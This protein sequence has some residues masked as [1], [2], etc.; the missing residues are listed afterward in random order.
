MKVGEEA[1]QEGAT[2]VLEELGIF[3][4]SVI[5]TY[6]I[7]GGAL[8]ITLLFK[9]VLDQLLEELHYHEQCDKSGFHIIPETNTVILSKLALS[10]FYLL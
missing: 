6:K 10:N 8:C 5:F 4:S 3:P 7:D 9:H 1:V 2:K